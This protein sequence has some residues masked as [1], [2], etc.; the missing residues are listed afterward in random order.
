MEEEVWKD[1]PNYEGLYQASNM[2]RIRSLDRSIYI[3]NYIPKHSK[4][5]VKCLSKSE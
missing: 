5:G 1:I 3:Y 4:K 2:G